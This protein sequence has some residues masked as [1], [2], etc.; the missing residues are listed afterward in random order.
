[1]AKDEQALVLLSPA[2]LDELE[3]EVGIGSVDFVAEDRMPEVGQ[4]DAELVQAAGVS[5]EA[6]ERCLFAGGDA[7]EFRF[8]RGGAAALGVVERD[9]AAADPDGIYG[10]DAETAERGVDDP[11]FL[12]N[13][14]VDKGEVGLG[15]LAAHG[16]AAEGRGGFGRAGGEDDAAGLAVESVGEGDEFSGKLLL[17]PAEEGGRAVGPGGMGEQIGRL[18]DDDEVGMGLDED[19]LGH[20]RPMVDITGAI[21]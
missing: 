17:E 11:V 8:C 5:L 13:A 7:P 16:H 4:V 10:R 19:G 2:M 18:G 20:G 9:D 3:V 14:A 15:D 12:L 1:M 6:E 21:I